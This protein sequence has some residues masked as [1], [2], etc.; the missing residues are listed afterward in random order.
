M[1]NLNLATQ[2][3]LSPLFGIGLEVLELTRGNMFDKHFV[4]SLKG[5]AS[6]LRQGR[7]LGTVHNAAAGTSSKAELGAE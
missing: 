4:Y 6:C 1:F 5:T 2:S 3:V 7:N